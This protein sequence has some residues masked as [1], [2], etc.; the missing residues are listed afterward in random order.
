MVV[1]DDRNQA[2][3]EAGTN[4][5]IVVHSGDAKRKFI[6]CSTSRFKG[7]RFRFHRQALPHFTWDILVD[8]STHSS[9]HQTLYESISNSSRCKSI[10]SRSVK[11]TI[12]VKP[13]RAE[14]L[15]PHPFAN[16]LKTRRQAGQRRDWSR[17]APHA[18]SIFP[19]SHRRR[20]EV[21][22]NDPSVDSPIVCDPPRPRV[23][24]RTL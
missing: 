9:I 23:L 11:I 5:T 4:R 10:K 7:R 19:S 2:G 24:K 21:G 13:H 8:F 1:P 22:R 6:L 16:L 14:R 18:R 12:T 20:P 3:T 17:K 15:H